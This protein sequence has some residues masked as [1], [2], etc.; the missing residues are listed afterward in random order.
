MPPDTVFE[1][2]S[3]PITIAFAAPIETVISGFGL[4]MLGQQRAFHEIVF[5]A[6]RLRR[7]CFAF[8]ARGMERGIGTGRQGAGL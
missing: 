3:N 7:A 4:G 8:N 6:E 5:L 1:A 2:N